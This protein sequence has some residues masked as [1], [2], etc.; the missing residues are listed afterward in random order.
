MSHI[1]LVEDDSSLGLTLQERLT[2]EGYSVDWYRNISEAKSSLQESTSYDL[3]VLDVG[4]PDGSGFDL[5][6]EI[7]QGTREIPFIFMTAASDAENRLQGFELGAEE[8]IPKPFHLKELFL[9][10]QHVLENHASSTI[11]FSESEWDMA[12]MSI[13][14]KSSQELTSLNGKENEVL[15]F[16]FESSPKAVSREEILDRVWGKDKFP[17]NRTI[18]NIIV[19][20]RQVLGEKDGQ[21]ILSV[22]GIGYQWL[23]LDQ[24]KAES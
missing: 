24:Q 23:A 10:V 7:S 11:H 18:D 22:R 4:L 5:A 12:A 9:R 21:R 1:L 14:K 19:R 17:S 13:R 15:K 16:L 8:F 6:R 2:K 20:L 3:A